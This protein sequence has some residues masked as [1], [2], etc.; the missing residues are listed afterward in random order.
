MP[1]TTV[2]AAGLGAC[3]FARPQAAIR[4]LAA[5][6]GRQ[7]RRRIPVLP[8]PEDALA[9]HGRIFLTECLPAPTVRT[10]SLNALRAR[11]LLRATPA[12]Q[13]LLLLFSSSWSALWSRFVP[14][15]CDTRRDRIAC[16]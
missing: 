9:G 3:G 2:R 4:C 6:T 15:H 14:R 10:R 5:F 13:Q 11:R 12:N 8:A 1:G 7:H 16:R